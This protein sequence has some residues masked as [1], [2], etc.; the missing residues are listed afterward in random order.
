MSKSAQNEKMRAK[1]ENWIKV[2]LNARLSQEID[3][4]DLIKQP[5]TC[6]FDKAHF[7]AVSPLSF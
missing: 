4:S 2:A 3:L 1:R 7:A 5:Q 6:E